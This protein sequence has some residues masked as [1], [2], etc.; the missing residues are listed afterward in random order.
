MKP[1]MRIARSLRLLS[2]VSGIGLASAP[3]LLAAAPSFTITATNL[4]LSGQGSGASQ[5]TLTSVGG[6]AG[7]VGMSCSGPRR[8]PLA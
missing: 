3:A 4:T 6:F 2:I 5:F 7:T 8:Q 1:A